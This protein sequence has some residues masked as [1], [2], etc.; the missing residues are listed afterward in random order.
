MHYK[1]KI[2][3][4]IRKQKYQKFGDVLDPSLII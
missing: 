4:K 1:S 3:E 2:F